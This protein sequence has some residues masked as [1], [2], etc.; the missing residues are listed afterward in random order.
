MEGRYDEIDLLTLLAKAIQ[1]IKN[2][3]LLIILAFFFGTTLGVAY[4]EFTRNVYESK[5]ILLSD[6]LTSSYS[7][8]ITESLT[9]LLDEG[10]TKELSKRLQIT[11]DDALKISRIEIQSVRQEKIKEANESSTFVVTVRVIENS[12]LP[13]LQAG[14]I[15]YLRNNDFVKIRVEQ[16][17]R[18]Y[19]TMIEKVGVELRSLDSLKRR[20]FLGQ[21]IYSKSAEMLLIDPTNIYSKIIELSREQINLRNSLELVNSIQLVEGFTPYKKPVSPKLLVSLAAGITMGLFFVVAIIVFKSI[22]SMLRFSEE[23]LGKSKGAAA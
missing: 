10:N 1:V 13:K 8:R 3:T 9:N 6:I 12:V 15:E 17:Q 19:S 7:E 16:R 2:N 23:Q 4:Y 22:R 14:L 18:Y 20:L 11:E 5:M 21:P